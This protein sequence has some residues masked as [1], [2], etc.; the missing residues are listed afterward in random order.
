MMIGVRNGQPIPPE[1]VL[2]NPGPKPGFNPRDYPWIVRY[3]SIIH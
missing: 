1:V 3:F 2:G